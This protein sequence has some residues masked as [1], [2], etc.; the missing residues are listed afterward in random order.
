[1]DKGVEK[2]ANSL[3]TDKKRNKETQEVLLKY[4]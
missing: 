3:E 2:E 4:I 1:M